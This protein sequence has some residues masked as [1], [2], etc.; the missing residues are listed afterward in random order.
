MYPA[1][2]TIYHRWVK[3]FETPLLC[4]L[5]NLIKSDKSD[6]KS[7]QVPNVTP[8]D[9]TDGAND[10]TDVTDGNMM[11]EISRQMSVEEQ[12][13]EYRCFEQFLGRKWSAWIGKTKVFNLIFFLILFVI[14]A[15]FGSQMEAQS[16]DEKWFADE[17]FMQKS[18]DEASEFSASETD[19]LV[20]LQITFGIV[21]VDR[22]G[23]SR[24][25]PVKYGEVIWDEDFD[26]SS[27]EAQ[28][29]LL[30]VCNQTKASDLVYSADLVVC[31]IEEFISYLNSTNE[32]F[33]YVQS[34]NKASFESVYNDFLKTD[35]AS[36]SRNN[37]LTYVVQNDDGEYVV[38]FYT[39][40]IYS[41][42]V[43][44]DP[45][46]YSIDYRTD[47]DE[48]IDEIK[49]NCPAGA[50]NLCGSVEN[51]SLRWC[52]L[53]TQKA[54]V[55]SAVQGILIA[56]PL[57]LIILMISTQNWI[58][59]VFAVLDIIGIML[60]ELSIMYLMG[61]KFGVSESVAVV[62]II[63]FSVDYVVHLANAYLESGAE[64]REERLSFALLT[65]GISV[66]SGAIT[67]FG[68]GFFL[69]FPPVI[70][71]YKMGVLM[72]S[73][74]AISIFWAMCF[75]TSIIAMWGP[76]G[77]TGDLKKYFKCCPGCKE[78]KKE[79]SDNGRTLEKRESYR[80][81]EVGDGDAKPYE[82][83][84]AGKQD[85]TNGIR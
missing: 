68:A 11:P 49:A 44:T 36:S 12:S 38:R 16:E 52:W 69:I 2:L 60:C 1:I 58:I 25:D 27:P 51:V 84:M 71:F 79:T 76:E 30:D 9:N 41:T 8:P 82:L 13:E 65:M 61:W 54:F 33:P 55:R 80:N 3:R 39:M 74:V 32:P 20:Q 72:I 19:G 21:G 28:Q 23:Y 15:I 67:T 77:D 73:T 37:A 42:I 22:D 5:C 6:E 40:Y 26:M 46:D 53:E 31:P 45:S 59:S 64:S 75:F 83:E 7:Q 62:I 63:G 4:C 85:N 81:Y 56:M 70:F 35:Y 50:E 66:V 57:A 47:W 10:D 34:G 48:F 29:Y 78:E 17:H 18:Q 43:W 24:W 14:A